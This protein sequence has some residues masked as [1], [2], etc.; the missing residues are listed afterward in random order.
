MESSFLKLHFLHMS[1]KSAEELQS[2]LTIW[3]DASL[4]FFLG[5][6]ASV[7]G[8]FPGS[9]SGWQYNVSLRE[10]SGLSSWVGKSPFIPASDCMTL[11]LD[12]LG[13]FS[14]VIAMGA[15]QI[16][17]PQQGAMRTGSAQHL[18]GCPSSPVALISGGLVTVPLSIPL[19][20]PL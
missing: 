5:W 6:G 10:V 4:V 19:N 3:G 14:R 7:P 13:L 18:S 11:V 8:G 9:E 20:L 2:W 15:K 17:C 16:K 1:I 12:S